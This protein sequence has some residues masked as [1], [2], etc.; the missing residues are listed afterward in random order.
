MRQSQGPDLRLK[1]RSFLWPSSASGA[2]YRFVLTTDPSVPDQ[3]AR[4]ALDWAAIGE[5]LELQLER[6]NSPRSHP[7]NGGENGMQI[8]STRRAVLQECLREI[9]E[10]FVEHVIK[11]PLYQLGDEL[12]HCPVLCLEPVQPVG[13]LEKRCWGARVRFLPAHKY[14]IMSA[15]VRSSRQNSTAS[16]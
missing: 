6:G 15:S 16:S 13:V 12:D 8:G 11:N 3:Q 14:L 7:E 9:Y 2:R 4:R 10:I 5:P 1:H